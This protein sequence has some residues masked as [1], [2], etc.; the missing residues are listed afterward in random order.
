MFYIIASRLPLV[1]SDSTKR[2]YLKLFIL[3]SIIYLCVHYYLF[4]EIRTG[5]LENI[6]SKLYYVMMIDFGI[7][8]ILTRFLSKPKVIDEEEDDENMVELQDSQDKLLIE[9]E[10]RKKYLA[11]QQQLQAQQQLQLQAQQQQQQQQ[12][13]QTQHKLREQQIKDKK[14][15]NKEKTESETSNTSSS[16]S[17]SSSSKPRKKK[18]KK[19][20]KSQN[21]RDNIREETKQEIKETNTD[22]EIP[23]YE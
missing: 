1:Y 7:S 6:K 23:V 3:G 13:L 12:Q 22:T 17:S 5:L 21:T 20:D 8:L 4:L 15:K 18:T 9:L 16:S 11:M 2:K 14:E 10:E 19:T